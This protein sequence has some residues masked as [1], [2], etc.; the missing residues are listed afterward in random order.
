M[1]CI[2]SNMHTVL[3][4]L[5]LFYYYFFHF[6]E[7]FTNIRHDYFI[8]IGSVYRPIEITM[9]KSIILLWWWDDFFFIINSM[10]IYADVDYYVTKTWQTFFGIVIMMYSNAIENEFRQPSQSTV[11]VS[12]YQSYMILTLESTF[13]LILNWL[14]YNHRKCDFFQF[15]Q[16]MPHVHRLK[17]P[18]VNRRK[19]RPEH[20]WHNAKRQYLHGLRTGDTTVLH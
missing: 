15:Q 18:L 16:L 13:L 20:R 10:T 4:P 5:V 2:P 6:A 7:F 14:V 9:T 11:S 19:P 8:D 3:L 12:G 1:Q 17:E